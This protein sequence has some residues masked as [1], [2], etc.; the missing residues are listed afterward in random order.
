MNYRMN[1]C[2]ILLFWSLPH[3]SYWM[4]VWGPLMNERVKAAFGSSVYVQSKIYPKNSYKIFKFC[5]TNTRTIN[6]VGHGSG[7]SCL[8]EFRALYELNATHVS[9]KQTCTSP[10]TKGFSAPP[11]RSTPCEATRSSRLGT[12]CSQLTRAPGLSNFEKEPSESTAP[13]PRYAEACGPSRTCGV[14]GSAP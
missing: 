11:E 6:P 5:P 2:A 14:R 7:N 10:P 12:P 1:V 8:G 3:L 4:N 9:T 13:R